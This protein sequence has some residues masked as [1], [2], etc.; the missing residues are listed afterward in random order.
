MRMS[1]IATTTLGLSG[2]L[3]GGG[4]DAGGAGALQ[5]RECGAEAA[6]PHMPFRIGT[7]AQPATGGAGAQQGTQ[8]E[9]EDLMKVVSDLLHDRMMGKMGGGDGAT[10]AGQADSSGGAQGMLQQI[11]E[12]NEQMEAMI[13]SMLASRQKTDGAGPTD[14]SPATPQMPQMQAPQAQ[15]APQGGQAP[16]APAAPAP[17]GLPQEDSGTVLAGD[18]TSLANK[19]TKCP[20][21][22]TMDQLMAANGG[23][24]GKLG[25]QKLAGDGAKMLEGGIKDN[26]AK[27]MGDT[28]DQFGRKDAN[29]KS[30]QA[31]LDATYRALQNV[32]AF[33]NTPGA[34]G[35]PIPDDIRH[36]GNVSGL[37]PSKEVARGSTLGEMQDWFKGAIDGPQKQLPKGDKVNDQGVE[38]SGAQQVGKKI[39]DGLSKVAGFFRDAINATIGKIPGI[40]KILSAP[41][42]L[43]AGGI[44]DGLKAA[45]DAAGG[46]MADAK[47]DGKEMGHNMLAT[48][49]QA[50]DQVGNLVKQTIG[51]LPGLGKL[52]AGAVKVGTN[53]ITGAAN[54]GDTA[55]K[56]GDVK[57]AAENMGKSAGGALAG[58]V[59]GAF[60]PT[61]KVED[62]TQKSVDDAL[63]AKPQVVA[64]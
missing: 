27:K 43:I 30:S 19:D 53:L 33:K 14:T 48:V 51:K 2:T 37:Q 9:N 57:G 15:A 21:G 61:G 11:I 55:L 20:P 10:G 39:L 58:A 29:G 6:M 7:V 28:A 23:V 31:D 42:N 8:S 63:G 59:V 13:A 25:N 17:A 44:S 12:Q 52:I 22:V 4:S 54:V 32:S 47:E 16:A 5:G 64:R 41:M 62:L 1:K 18:A 50:A 34:D 35:K 49:S 45:G 3:S 24:L 38:T 26:L 36:N 60:D 56:G 46:H 40:G